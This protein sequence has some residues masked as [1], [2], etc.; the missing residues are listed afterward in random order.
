MGN[1]N[2]LRHVTASPSALLLPR[3]EGV[4]TTGKG[5]RARCPAH[6]GKSASL[7]IA[8]G[9]NNTL[10]LHCFT[11]CSV[12]DVLAAVGLEVGDL[13]VRK[14]LRSM[15]PAERSQLRQAALLPKW[16]AALE[17]LNTEAGAVLIAAD[18]LADNQPLNDADLTRLRVACLRIFD[19]TEV[20]HAHSDL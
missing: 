1:N 6:G 17:V 5:W 2:E 4:I 18:Q 19:A 8:E 3:L 14:D 13:F 7:S 12:H 10:L 15:S 16:R 20:L 11:G 9:D